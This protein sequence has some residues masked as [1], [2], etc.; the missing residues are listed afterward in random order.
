[1]SYSSHCSLSKIYTVIYIILTL[2]SVS[3]SWD[4][5]KAGADWPGKCHGPKQSPIDISLPF[6][7]YKPNLSFSYSKMQT[8]YMYY[9][10]GNNLIVEGDFG[11]M[12]YNDVTYLSSQILLYSPSFHTINNKRYPLEMQIIH[13]DKTG[14]Q[15]TVC[16]MFKENFLILRSQRFSP[17]IFS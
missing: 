14:K 13:H 9:N 8:E 4:F 10:D 15:L 17:A 16:V 2:C 1:M 5:V 6:T 3:H 12:N 7:Y 11:F